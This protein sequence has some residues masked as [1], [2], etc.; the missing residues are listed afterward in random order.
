MIQPKR[1]APRFAHRRSGDE[2][3]EMVARDSRY[4]A[5]GGRSGPQFTIGL[6]PT[7]AEEIQLRCYGYQRRN[8]RLSGCSATRSA[9]PGSV[10]KL[11]SGNGPYRSAPLIGQRRAQLGAYA[12]RVS[13]GSCS[14][15]ADA[16][17]MRHSDCHVTIDPERMQGDAAFAVQHRSQHTSPTPRAGATVVAIRRAAAQRKCPE[18]QA[19]SMT[20]RTA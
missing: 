6:S 16:S 8:E 15:G 18:P 12:A 4:S 3:E 5:T 20:A 10:R 1:P 17:R 9:K 14:A 7:G 11:L 13:G 2:R 19:G